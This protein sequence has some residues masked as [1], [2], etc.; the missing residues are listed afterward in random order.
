M[1]D[2]TYDPYYPSG[3]VDSPSES[4]PILAAALDR[5]DDGITA[6]TDQ[7]NTA[8]HSPVDWIDVVN[9]HGADPTGVADSHAAIQAAINAAAAKGGGVV[10]F[11]T[12]TFNSSATLSIPS[13]VTLRG[14][15]VAGT[16]GT[17]TTLVM[18]ASNTNLLSIVGTSLAPLQSIS[19]CDMTLA[20]PGK[21]SGSTGFGIDIEWAQDSVVFSNILVWKHGSHGVFMTNTYGVTWRDCWFTQNGGHGF[22]GLT[23]VN[24]VSWQR[25]LFD[26]N[27]MSGCVIDGAA[28]SAFY[29]CDFESNVNNGLEMRYAFACGVYNS[30]LENNGT[31]GTSANVYVHWHASVADK[32][33]GVLIWN[34]NISG[35]GITAYGVKVDGANLARIEMCQ[36]T[37]Q[38]TA[39]IITTSNSSRTWIGPNLHTGSA[40]SLTDASASTVVLDYDTS[41]LCLRAK[42]G[43][44]FQPSTP[45]VTAVPGLLWYTTGNQFKFYDGTTTRTIGPLDTVA[46]DIQPL[47]TPAAGSSGLAADAKHVH[48]PPAGAGV[49]A[50]DYG[51]SA[52]NEDPMAFLALTANLVAGT[53][54]VAKVVVRSP[55]TISKI[56]IV[57]SNAPSM[58]AGS[59]AFLALYN[60]AGAQIGVTSDQ[61]TVWNAAGFYSPSIGSQTLTPGNYY[62]V[63]IVGA[64]A[65]PSITTAPTTPVINLNAAGSGI[66]ESLNIAATAPRWGTAGTALTAVPATINPNSLGNTASKTFLFWT[67]LLP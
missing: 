45:P 22:Y 13:F 61:S 23:S 18:T 40:A 16:G 43:I 59:G 24:V 38:V 32:C 21:T 27:G 30:D 2:I 34:C 54:Y 52:M 47:G 57:I 44:E 26:A 10:S 8:L 55:V 33:Q 20:G 37:N 7:A 56:G 67:A 46:T 66:M 5:I 25:C 6:A 63:F 9:D 35:A 4:T 28:G 49:D 60:S 64:A 12:G 14:A 42:P 3:W 15:G 17:G 53:A 41:N 29:T 39:D 58:A 19:V 1:A 48:A 36:F 51:F 11:P 50:S 65:S 31:D 62:V